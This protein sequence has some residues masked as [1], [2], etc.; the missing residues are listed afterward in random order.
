[1]SV[2]PPMG[3]GRVRLIEIVGYDLQPC[4]GTH[5]R[6]TSEIG[7]VRVTQIEKK[8]KQN[9]R[10]RIA[11]AVGTQLCGREAARAVGWFRRTGSRHGSMPRM[12]SWST[13]LG[14]CRPCSAIRQPNI[15]P[16]IFQAR[17][18][19]MSTRSPIIPIRCLTCCRGAS[20]R[21][22]WARSASP[23]PT[24]SWSMTAPACSRHRGCGG[25][26]ACS[27]PRRCSFSMAGC[28]NGKAKAVRCRPGR[29]TRPPR[30]FHAREPLMWSPRVDDVRAALERQAAQVVDARSA[31]R[32]Q[33]QAPEPRAGVRSGHMPGAFNVPVD[34]GRGERQA[35]RRQTN[36][37]LRLSQ[38][39][40]SR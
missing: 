11:F 12:W 24:A 26:F 5:V 1:M 31:E 29:L 22:K 10:V 13:A 9:R 30:R 27:A 3:T 33:G 16:A 34:R 6:T 20:S 8:G 32:F 25:R 37:R 2:K 40:R 39:R 17:C 36:S 18:A 38:R 28:R 14:T 19:S 21:A 35:R 7:E 4:G 15:S 23:I